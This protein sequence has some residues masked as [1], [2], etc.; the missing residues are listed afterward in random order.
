MRF[1]SL[2]NFSFLAA[3]SIL[4]LGFV[5]PA[6][7]AA[8]DVVDLLGPTQD[9][10]LLSQRKLYRWFKTPSSGSAISRYDL[11]ISGPSGVHN[12]QITPTDAGCS[13]T[14]IV[15]C[16]FEVD[17]FDGT[18]SNMLAGTYQ[19]WVRAENADGWGLW[20]SPRSYRYEPVITIAPADGARV[21]E[22]SGLDHAYSWAVVPGA[23]WYQLYIQDSGGNI[24]T[25]WHLSLIHI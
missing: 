2:R 9:S 10:E 21:Q 3:V 25:Q 19:W 7:A 6:T 17:G 12:V 18:G 1:P 5:T 24:D 8:P 23:T 20:G 13:A 11:Y 15:I 14:F 16:G 4:S 22:V